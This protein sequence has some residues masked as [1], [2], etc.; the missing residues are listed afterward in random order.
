MSPTLLFG[1]SFQNYKSEVTN[2]L[3]HKDVQPPILLILSGPSGVGKDAVLSRMRDLEEPYHFTVTT[4]TRTK[5]NGET[6]GKDYI[7]VSQAEFR[8]Q[9]EQDG[10]LEWA[11]VYGNYY[12]VPRNQVKTA[13][14]KGKDVIVKIDVQGA[15]TIKS[16]APNALYIFLAPPSM[17]QL[18]KRLKERMT[19][20]PDSL[21]IRFETAAEEMKSAGWFDHVVINHENQLDLAVAEIQNVVKIARLKQMETPNFEII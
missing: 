1:K 5:R 14:K 13:L 19:E 20:S 6:D 8:A 21:K 9:M 4:T 12:G 7:F 15:K 11:E 3:N 10:F 16:L 17:D 18:E 2:L